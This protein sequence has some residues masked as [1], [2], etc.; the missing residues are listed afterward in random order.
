MLL[1]IMKSVPVSIKKN[2][3]KIKLLLTNPIL[4]LTILITLL[5]PQLARI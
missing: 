4:I 3:T 1:R 2:N 5:N